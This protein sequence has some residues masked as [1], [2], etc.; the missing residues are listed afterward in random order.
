MVSV[1]TRSRLLERQYLSFIPLICAKRVCGKGT[2]ALQ[3]VLMTYLR[4]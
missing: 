3:E 4:R 1:E 2:I